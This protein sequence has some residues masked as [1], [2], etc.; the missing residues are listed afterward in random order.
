MEGT[1]LENVIATLKLA[2]GEIG[3]FDEVSNTHLTQKNPIKQVVAGTN[4]SVLRRSV[5]CGRLILLIGSLGKPRTLKEI[6]YCG[7]KGVTIKPAIPT[8]ARPITTID[9]TPNKES[10]AELAAKLTE[11]Q[12]V[13]EQEVKAV[14]E[15][16]TE[17]PVANE[18]AAAQEVEL[19]TITST[20]GS[21]RALK[22]GDIRNLSVDVDGAIFKSTDEKIATVDASGIVNGV[23]V[24]QTVIT[25]SAKD[26]A[27]TTVSVTVVEA[28][29]K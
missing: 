11:A 18:M 20:P 16:E 28:E 25:I 27:D 26:C 17:A 9:V 3:Y 5:K 24:G 23:M 1:T 14:Q 10:E 6:L 15:T 12:K 7:K 8:I 2:P 21:V 29:S 13:D 19:K 22:V 4:C